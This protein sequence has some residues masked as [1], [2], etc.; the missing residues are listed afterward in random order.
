MAAGARDL[1][2]PGVSVLVRS[3]R[4][5]TMQAWLIRNGST[6]CWRH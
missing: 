3:W 6:L 4:I 5:G 1:P 2:A